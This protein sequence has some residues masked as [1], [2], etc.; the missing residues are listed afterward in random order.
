MWNNGYKKL[1]VGNKYDL[2]IKRIVDYAKAKV[3]RFCAW[4][5]QDVFLN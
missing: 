2:T 5:K 4:K 1:I 3:K